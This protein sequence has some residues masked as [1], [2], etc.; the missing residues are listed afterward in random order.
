MLA[1]GFA[2]W[3]S[4]FAARFRVAIMTGTNRLPTS[5]SYPALPRCYVVKVHCAWSLHTLPG[6]SFT[7]VPGISDWLLLSF[8]DYTI[9]RTWCIVNHK[10][11]KFCWKR[12]ICWILTITYVKHCAL[13]QQFALL[14]FLA[15]AIISFGK[16][17]YGL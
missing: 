1:F 8:C 15:D 13:S 5:A 17:C 4:I 9:S 2:V 7:A 6:N 3:I 14:F 10:F 12:D 16:W 11:A